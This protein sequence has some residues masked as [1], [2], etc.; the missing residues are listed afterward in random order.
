[1]GYHNKHS[2][3]TDEDGARLRVMYEV[4]EKTV[5]EISKIE[6]CGLSTLRKA[7]VFFGIKPRKDKTKKYNDS[8]K[9]YWTDEQREHISKNNF[10]NPK[11]Q[12]EYI[13]QFIKVHGTRYDYSKVKYNG[14]FAKITIVCEEHG[15]F[16]QLP[17]NHVSGRGCPTCGKKKL[18]GGYN[19]I[20]LERNPEI[21]RSPAV[22]YIVRLF[23]DTEDFIKCGITIQTVVSRIS[24]QTP[25][26]Y[27]ILHQ[28]NTTLIEAYEM[29]QQFIK[30]NNEFSYRP[31]NK[32]NG[33]TECFSGG[34]L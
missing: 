30:K 19:I 29:E 8:M 14:C 5:A 10:N 13:E 24:G 15:E 4:E 11:T 17:S 12:K 2:G 18:I 23:N 1:M 25:Y 31:N 33:W 28:H 26:Q 20:H 22:F 7:F 32:F 3:F 9:K 27:E 21:K 34:A 6:R 16:A